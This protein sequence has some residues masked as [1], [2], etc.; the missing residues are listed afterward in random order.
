MAFAG[1]ARR[2]FARTL[3]SGSLTP[4][5]GLARMYSQFV[6]RA[7]LAAV[8]ACSSQIA[9]A[10]EMEDIIVTGAGLEQTLPQ[11]IARYGSAIE[12]VTERQVRDSGAM[13]VA[14][15]LQSV[16]GL[17]IRPAS[18]PFSYVDLALQGSRTKDVLWT[19]DGIRINNRL[20]GGTSPN[21][22]LP[23][24]MIERVE[25][26]KGGES[27]FYGTQAA[28]GVINVVTRSFTDDFNGQANGSV[29]SR[30]GTS[31]DGYVRGSIGR[32]RFVAYASHNRA[33][34]YRPFTE[35]EPSAT[36]RRRGYDVW[37]VGG[38]YQ[39][40][41]GGDIAL[42]LQYQHT[43]AN[44]DNANATLVRESRNDRNEEIASVR[45]DYTGSDAIQFFLKGYYH[46]WKTA[47]VQIRNDLATGEPITIF[48]P[49]TF[50]GY[51]DYGASALVKMRPHRGLEYLVGYDYQKF[52]GRDDVLLIGKTRENVHAG[53]FQVRTTDD[54]SRRARLAAGLRYN[55]TGGA[56]KTVWNV[57]GRFDISDD[58]YVEGVGG[59]SF[60]LPDASQLYQIDPCC[61]K[62]N[63]NL[64]PE[65]SLNLNATLGGKLPF[66]GG[67]VSWQAG[68][69]A[70]R[71]DNLIDVSYDDPAYPDGIF[72]NSDGRVKVRGVDAQA[73][74]ALGDGWQLS[75]SYSYTRSRNAGSDRQRDRT[76]KQ[77]A[78]G[79]IAYAPAGLPFGANV[80]VNWV[81]DARSTLPGFGRR[82]YGNYA[83]VDIGLHFYPDGDARR[84]R[85][86]INIE[87]LFDREYATSGYRT[88]PRDD[89]SGRFLYGVRGVPR[90]LRASYG[91]SF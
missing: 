34:G 72:M 14:T 81:G 67:A 37:S 15:A 39:Y 51:R 12:V 66:A 13:D 36:D 10:G 53:I 62:G 80:T 58:L 9:H 56:K 65:E 11:E 42:N 77:F 83:L 19:V 89:G 24:S 38:K 59:T 21:D 71:I 47:Y 30:A 8:I 88:A 16:P 46:D 79:A 48:P 54:L 87:N 76:P 45:L 60:L 64:A 75:A 44:L 61:E 74:A 23:A 27:L 43:E 1:H 57:T 73:A 32:H 85:V 7:A 3:P 90:T 18:G 63:P 40:D 50:W 82:N 4:D 86:G 70:R 25:V 26:L 5:G 20:Y 55:E 22:T 52:N 84:H 31:L 35:M 29:D 68:L 49:G 2:P 17:Y 91:L 41:F 78:S 6:S 69:F 33:E 28:A